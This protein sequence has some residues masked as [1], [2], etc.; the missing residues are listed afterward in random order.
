MPGILYLQQEFE[1]VSTTQWLRPAVSHRSIYLSA[2]QLSWKTGATGQWESARSHAL[3]LR[4][5]IPTLT[6]TGD[7]KNSK[8]LCGS[9]TP[10]A[11]PSCRTHM[12]TSNRQRTRTCGRWHAAPAL[13]WTNDCPIHT[14]THTRTHTH[15]HLHRYTACVYCRHEWEHSEPPRCFPAEKS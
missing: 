7:P 12:H 6:R 5:C 2:W 14:H 4:L 1:F 8:T 13:R 10:A 9:Q 3:L 11:F 15:T